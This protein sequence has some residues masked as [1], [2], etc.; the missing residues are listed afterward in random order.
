MFPA[1]NGS[2]A[3][4]P[5][6]KKAERRIFVFAVRIAAH[7]REVGEDLHVLFTRKMSAGAAPVLGP[8]MLEVVGVR[9]RLVDG[10]EVRRR[11]R[12]IRIGCR[13]EAAGLE[14]F[15]EPKQPGPV[16]RPSERADRVELI[17]MTETERRR[18]AAA[19]RKS[20]DRAMREMSRAM[21]RAGVCRRRHL[22]RAEP[23]RRKQQ[24]V[25]SVGFFFD[26]RARDR[27]RAR[28]TCD[29]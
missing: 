3:D 18:A 11:L 8:P 27:N 20:D 15:D 19:H 1:T 17:V 26:A 22:I 2:V 10:V 12:A 16:A 14:I 9:V 7:E 4:G 25:I 24:R 6:A 29:G 28:R 21:Q 23:R 5:R 13:T